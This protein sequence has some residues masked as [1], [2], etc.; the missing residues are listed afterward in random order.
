MK[1]Q[2]SC[3]L[4]FLWIP[5]FFFIG[6]CILEVT[7]SHESML[8]S[9]TENGAHE[10]L[11]FLIIT[12]AAF[13]PLIYFVS[14]KTNKDII[15]KAW[16]ALAFV[17]CVYVAGEEVSWGQHF[18]NWSTPEN[19]EAVNDQQET[20]LHNTSSWLDQ[21]PRII[22]M[23]GIIFGTLVLPL[24]IKKNILKLPEKLITL[25]PVKEFSFLAIL[26]L[27]TH[28]LEKVLDSA[29]MNFFARFSEVQEIML[30]YFVLLYLAN[31]YHKLKLG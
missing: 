9:T 15:Y 29:D 24:L 25:I 27:A 12:A 28:I 19:W 20:N 16:F 3:P 30:F 5:L 18:F 6:Q 26:I 1:Q 22:L 2:I 8:V 13:I 21:K 10:L 31:L 14:R 7:L 11:Q 23:A 17:C 4:F